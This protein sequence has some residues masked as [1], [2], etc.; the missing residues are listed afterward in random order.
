MTPQEIQQI[1]RN[2]EYIK[3]KQLAKIELGNNPSSFQFKSVL[4]WCYYDEIKTLAARLDDNQNDHNLIQ[5]LITVYEEYISGD[6]KRPDMAFSLILKIIAKQSAQINNFLSYIE[7]M[8]MNALKDE[9]W[10]NTEFQGKTFP[11]IAHDV[12]RG[13][14]KWV[15]SH[16]NATFNQGQLALDWSRTV[17]ANMNHEDA[18]WL[19]WDVAAVLRK[20][21]DYQKSAEVLSNVLKLKQNEFWVWREAARIYA[22]EDEDLAL[23]CYCKAMLC[24]SQP[25][26]L[27]STHEEFAGFL[28]ELEIYD[29]ASYEINKALE[30]R[31]NNSWKIKEDLQVLCSNEW[32]DP[33][34]NNH[35]QAQKFYN[36]HSSDALTLCFENIETIPATYLGYI[37]IKREG[38][39]PKRMIK[40]SIKNNTSHESTLASGFNKLQLEEGDTVMV[41][42]GT[43]EQG[44]RDLV[45]NIT[46]SQDARKWQNT[47][48]VRA[49]VSYIGADKKTTKLFVNKDTQMRVPK[50]LEHLSLSLG[51]QVSCH[52]AIH[53]IK[54]RIEVFHL[55]KISNNQTIPDSKSLSG[56]LRKNEKGFGFIDDIFIAPHLIKD[57]DN[58]A[59][60]KIIALYEKPPKREEYS[61]RAL[62]VEIK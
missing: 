16:D 42:K 47:D 53:P 14:C 24:R 40:L 60:L 12:A 44:A 55:D 15:K 56:I 32:Y 2:G 1:R 54:N 17:R 50:H 28:A 27:V 7:W 38:K 45:I 5:K 49:L 25:N 8:G 36:D 19:D 37:E 22:H 41:T 13:M 4:A 31:N 26:F 58:G 59:E 6:P 9:D 48:I 23:A 34:Q 51:E 10:H 18:V 21:G 43:K 61:W 39:K 57:I 30:I 62:S 29:R 33:E 46:K 20:L 3:A 11:P 52:T 35:Q